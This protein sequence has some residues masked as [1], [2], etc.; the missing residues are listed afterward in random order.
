MAS[1]GKAM[2]ATLLRCISSSGLVLAQPSQG[3]DIDR[4]IVNTRDRPQSYFSTDPSIR[5]EPL[6]TLE[7]RGMFKILPPEPEGHENG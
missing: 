6:L 3:Q 1:Y 4:Q 2:T 5:N 7:Q